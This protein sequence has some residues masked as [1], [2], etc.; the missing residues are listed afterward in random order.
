L[1]LYKHNCERFG[2]HIVYKG[3]QIDRG[4]SEAPWPILPGGRDA[5]LVLG[6]RQMKKVRAG[7]RET[8][9]WLSVS[10]PGG[11]IRR[12]NVQWHQGPWTWVS[13]SAKSAPRRSGDCDAVN[14][15]W[16]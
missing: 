6:T 12:T 4:Y 13:A 11:R 9:R 10:I 5:F 14:W 3:Q 2:S 7:K 16:P 1:R 8:A 15:T